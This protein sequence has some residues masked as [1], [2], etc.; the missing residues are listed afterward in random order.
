MVIY[1]IQIY[2]EIHSEYLKDFKIYFWSDGH[3]E[4]EDLQLAQFHLLVVPLTL[5]MHML[6][7]TF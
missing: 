4:N 1:F 3:Q 7:I 2:S 6:R 5:N